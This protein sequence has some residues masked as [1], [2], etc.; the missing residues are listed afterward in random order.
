MIG[1]SRLDSTTGVWA[2]PGAPVEID[3]LRASSQNVQKEYQ[4]ED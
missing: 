4:K 1:A 3:F 2:E